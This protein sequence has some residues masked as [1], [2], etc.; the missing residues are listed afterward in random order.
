M[1]VWMTDAKAKRTWH[2][3]HKRNNG[4]TPWQRKINT[5]NVQKQ[6]FNHGSE[7]SNT[8]CVTT[9]MKREMTTKNIRTLTEHWQNTLK[10]FHANLLFYNIKCSRKFILTDHWSSFLLA[11]CSNAV[12]WFYFPH[13]NKEQKINRVCKLTA[14]GIEHSVAQ[15]L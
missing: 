15:I 14:F 2:F 12:F 4:M 6:Q 8:G 13:L 9:S 3:T 5:C 7:S 10:T 11:R 1:Y